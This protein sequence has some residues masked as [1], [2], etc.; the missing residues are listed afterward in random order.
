[1]AYIA[2]RVFVLDATR[3]A[4]VLDNA[5][6]VRKLNI[7]NDWN[8]IYIGLLAA[9]QGNGTVQN[10]IV[11]WGLGICSD[12][13]GL[14]PASTKHFVGSYSASSQLTYT[15]NSGNPYYNFQPQFARKVGTAITTAN[16]GTIQF[17]FPIT[18]TVLRKAPL[19]VAITRNSATVYGVQ[20]YAMAAG[21][22]ATDY[23]I[24]NLMESM[25]QV[26]TTPAAKGTS[27]TLSTANTLNGSETDGELNTLSIY[28]GSTLFPLEVY[29]IAV[30]RVR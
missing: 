10:R 9:T 21:G 19:W 14:S 30:Y 3:K 20:N 15:A 25:E 23:T 22:M 11:R 28:W 26:G 29:G 7:G 1:M 17:N 6:F 27:F 16:I 12:M 4:L 13:S 18:E 2:E 8:Q 24:E 5:E